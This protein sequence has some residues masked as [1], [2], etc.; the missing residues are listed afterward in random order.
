MKEVGYLNI[1]L[2]HDKEPLSASVAEKVI[3]CLPSLVFVYD[4]ATEMLHFVNATV[5]KFTRANLPQTATLKDVLQ[6]IIHPGD[7]ARI[8]SL[9][10]PA[11]SVYFQQNKGEA[12]ILDPNGSYRWHRIERLPAEALGGEEMPL[13]LLIANDMQEELKSKDEFETTREL[14]DETEELLQFGSWTWELGTNTVTWTPG[15]YSIL[16]YDP[17]QAMEMNGLDFFLTHVQDEYHGAFE[18]MLGNALKTR[19]DFSFEYVVRTR[20]GELKDISTKGKLLKNESG[21]VL[22]VLCINRDVTAVRTFEKEQ[23][24]SIRELNRSNRDLEEFAYIA[25]HDLQEPLRKISMFTERLKAKYNNALDADGDLFIDRILA[26]AANMRTLIDNLLEFSRANRRLVNF[27]RVDL[28]AVLDGVVSEFDLK[29]EETNATINFSGTMPVIEAVTSEMKQLFCN[30]LSNAIKFRK[31]DSP[32]EIN[33]KGGKLTKGE[34]QALGLPSGTPFVRVDVQD[35]GIGFDPEYSEKI[36]QI[37]QRLNGKSEYPG[38][39]IGLAI[40]KKIVE[41]HSGLIFAKGQ[42]DAGATITVILPEKKL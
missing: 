41:K 32:V 7:I 19:T 2:R 22:K 33:I 14:L 12:R 39:G 13:M 8:E 38:S 1:F 23:E 21:D 30:I 11:W 3:N 29:I 27:D 18:E 26:S 17:G 35:N 24:R 31:A 34:K 4:A 36:F 16:G 42:P 28:K 10:A 37:F 15:L 25:S 5:K 20:S 40:C 9:L 6:A